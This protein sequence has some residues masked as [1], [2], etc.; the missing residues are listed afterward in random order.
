MNAELARARA[1]GWSPAGSGAASEVQTSEHDTDEDRLTPSRAWMALFPYVAV[2]AVFGFVNLW[3][4][5]INVPEALEKTIIK[6]PW[7]VLHDAL[8]DSSGQRQSS[9]VYSFEWLISP[10]TLL[11]ITGLIVTVAYSR[12]T[13]NGRYRLSVGASLREIG[14]TALRMRAAA[15]TILAVLALAYVMNFSGQ[16]VSI[17]TWLAATGPFF[18]FLSPVLGWIG[19]AVTGS[20]TSANALFAKLQQTAGLEAGINP[21]L[22]VAANTGGGV[23]GKL[24]SPQNLAIGAAAVNMSG[25]E[26]VLLRKVVGWSALLLLALCILVYLQSTPVLEWMLP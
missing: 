8:L 5:G 11:L 4:W 18:A 16:T 2:I 1:G 7:P 14:T 17:G 15:L 19:T 25:Q 10:G 23:M 21:Q 26:S 13:E 12:F 6:I 3:T 24:I 20:D 22:L 9:T